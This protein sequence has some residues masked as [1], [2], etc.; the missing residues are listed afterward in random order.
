[1]THTPEMT[2]AIKDSILKWEGIVQGTVEDK[3]AGNCALC[4]HQKDYDGYVMCGG[5]PLS[6]AGEQCD[7]DG[8][9]YNRFIS[10]KMDDG[11]RNKTLIA[12]EM[13]E[14]LRS[15]LEK[16]DVTLTLT[17]D[18]VQFLTDVTACIGGSPYGT[19]RT[20]NNSII[21]K[22]DRFGLQYNTSDIRGSLTC[23]TKEEVANGDKYR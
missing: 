14:K 1:M 10:T 16:P 23:L 15:F 17:H 22:L 9:L 12:Y 21:K 18:E 8:S 2:K 5:C 3:G 4:Q 20:I 19:R 11:S 13:V 7:N 6:E